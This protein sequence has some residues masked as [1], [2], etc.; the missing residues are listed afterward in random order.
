[1]D[2][3]DLVLPTMIAGVEAVD[4]AGGH[5]ELEEL[6]VVVVFR[7][8]HDQR[9]APGNTAAPRKRRLLVQS[10]TP[11]LLAQSPSRESRAPV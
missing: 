3:S 10:P 7:G 11:S 2:E 9:L 8:E 6:A 5:D 4:Q 1:M